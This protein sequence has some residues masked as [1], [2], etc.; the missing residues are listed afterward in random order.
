M[1]VYVPATVD[2]LRT[3]QAY[4]NDLGVVLRDVTNTIWDTITLNMC[5]DEALA[6]VQ[7]SFP[8]T[9]NWAVTITDGSL[10]IT[11]PDDCVRVLKVTRAN[12]AALKTPPFF[13]PV[14]YRVE[15][16]GVYPGYAGGEAVDNLIVVLAVPPESGYTYYVRYVAATQVWGQW[17]VTN[18]GVDTTATKD[19]NI[20]DIGDG[21]ALTLFWAAARVAALRWAA[22][23]V[24]SDGGREWA[25]EFQA[26]LKEREGLRVDLGGVRQLRVLSNLMG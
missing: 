11:P 10:V 24:A 12:P 6:F 13:E 1:P 8:P 25:T 2:T 9:R 15:R 16:T 7:E 22:Q 26:A 5:L 3:R 19:L 4:R 18:S 17:S 20:Y 23:A 21:P 14:A